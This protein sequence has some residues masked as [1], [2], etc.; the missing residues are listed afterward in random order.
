[1]IDDSIYTLKRIFKTKPKYLQCL[2]LFEK[3]NKLDL[4]E[5]I[6]AHKKEFKKT[7]TRD[8]ALNRLYRLCLNG[9]IKHTGLKTYRFRSSSPSA[10][11]LI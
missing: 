2:V 9:H 6:A 1:M 8:K 3:H 7:I 11:E 10:E 4:D 5:F